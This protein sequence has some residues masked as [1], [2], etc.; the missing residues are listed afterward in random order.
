MYIV[1]ARSAGGALGRAMGHYGVRE[2]PRARNCIELV[3]YGTEGT[4]LAQYHDMRYV[5]TGRDGAIRRGGRPATAGELRDGGEGR[6]YGG[7]EAGEM[8]EIVED[9]LYAGRQYYFNNEVHGM[10][11]GEFANY[12]EHFAGAL[13]DGTPNSPDLAE[14]VETEAQL[15]A[16]RRAGALDDQ[17]PLV[18]AAV[19]YLNEPWYC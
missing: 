18:R 3:L 1:N 10:H 14:G 7:F 19:P 17:A 6:E 12:L 2:L 9:C 5:H 13:I 4:S 15:E 8:E 16:A 11:Y